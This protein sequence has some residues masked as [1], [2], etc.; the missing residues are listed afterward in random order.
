MARPTATYRRAITIDHTQVTGTLTDFPLM[1]RISGSDATALLDKARW[2]GQD[3]TLTTSDGETVVPHVRHYT[4]KAVVTDGVWTWYT[5]PRAFHYAGHGAGGVTYIGIVGSD[6]N[7]ALVAHDHATGLTTFRKLSNPGLDDHTNTTVHVT[8]TGRLLC[9]TWSHGTG[10][11]FTH[12]RFGSTTGDIDATITGTT[13]TMSGYSLVGYPSYYS[14]SSG[15]SGPAERVVCFFYAV[16]TATPSAR[17]LFYTYSD[18]DGATWSTPTNYATA[19]ANYSYVKHVSD[20]STK[21][22]M[23]ITDY[24]PTYVS[25]NKLYHMVFESSAGTIKFYKSDATEITAGLPFDAQTE[26]T[27]VYDST[28]SN[29]TYGTGALNWISGIELDGTGKPGICFGVFPGVTGPLNSVPVNDCRYVRALWNGSS[30]DLTEICRG[31]DNLPYNPAIEFVYYGG[32]CLKQG[33]PSVAYAATNYNTRMASTNDGP[34]EIQEWTYSG[35]WSKTAD[36]TQGSGKGATGAFS[37]QHFRPVW[38]RNAHA[39][40]QVLWCSGR[41]ANYND[42]YTSIHSYPTVIGSPVVYLTAKVPS[43]DAS[44]DTTLYLYYGHRDISADSQAAAASVLAANTK[45]FIPGGDYPPDSSKVYEIANGWRPPKLSSLIANP[46]EVETGG[47]AKFFRAIKLDGSA[48]LPNNALFA[49]AISNSAKAFTVMAWVRFGN[50]GATYDRQTILQN[51]STSAGLLFRLRCFDGTA[52][53][54]SGQGHRFEGFTIDS[55]G[56]A[57]G[58]QFFIGQTNI[59]AD[60]WYHV[61]LTFSEAD[62]KLRGYLNGAEATETYTNASWHTTASVE[63]QWGYDGSNHVSPGTMIE[64]ARFWSGDSTACLSA[65]RIATIYENESAPETFALLG[66]ETLNTLSGSYVALEA[67]IRGLNRGIY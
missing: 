20:G 46:R 37:Y 34:H 15:A 60:T 53:T 28:A 6:G 52:S 38:V 4:G 56:G 54:S 48:Y 2:D 65:G 59:S 11:T 66:T 7:V 23:G 22:H 51:Y 45:L 19:G 24:I 35:G 29:L 14:L 21:V 63:G 62:N 39:D 12:Q 47:G 55:G 57:V 26:A 67:G 36:V 3:L 27:V 43:I 41:Y 8:G 10:N 17:D 5:D 40:A 13:V 44:T 42:Y 49:A 1:V 25:S 50:V 30:W 9:A 64:R 31:G 16:P 58:G 33:D 32:V 18:D 61:A